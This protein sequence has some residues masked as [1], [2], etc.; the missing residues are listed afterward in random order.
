MSL[1]SPEYQVFNFRWKIKRFYHKKI[2]DVTVNHLIALQNYEYLNFVC[3][4]VRIKP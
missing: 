4:I 1:N 3:I 2:I